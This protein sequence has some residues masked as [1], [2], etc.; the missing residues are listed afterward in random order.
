M[1][2]KST[3]YG[4][5]HDVSELDDYYFYPREP[6]EKEDMKT[7]FIQQKMNF[8]EIKKAFS[9][10]E[11]KQ[12]LFKCKV[13][14]MNTRGILDDL[15]TLLGVSQDLYVE[16][17]DNNELENISEELQQY[18]MSMPSVFH[19]TKIK[20]GKIIEEF[21]FLFTHAKHFNDI[22]YP[23]IKAKHDPHSDYKEYPEQNRPESTWMDINEACADFVNDTLKLE[24]R[25]TKIF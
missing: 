13:A 20:N 5:N 1:K 3:V 21:K 18:R 9:S 15:S 11:R 14:Y 19:L 10:S 7:Y 2:E 23:K 8:R 24:K 22:I 16:D 25:L 6:H 4:F 17:I 12:L